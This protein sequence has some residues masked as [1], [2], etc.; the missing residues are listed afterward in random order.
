MENAHP[1]A[2]F[3]FGDSYV[4]TG[5]LKKSN[6]VAWK[7]P[8]GISFPGKPSGRHSDGKVFTD[9]IG[10][11]SNFYA[12]NYS[13]RVW[14]LI[15]DFNV[16]ASAF[17]IPIPVLHSQRDINSNML[18]FGMNFATGGTGVFSTWPRLPST[19]TQINQL[20]ELIGNGVYSTKNLP[21][22]LVLFYVPSNTYNAFI[23]QQRGTV[24]VIP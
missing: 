2:M 19:N 7:P 18:R 16:A 20:Q 13:F 15:C 14:V 21:S 3:V 8:Y 5:N 11:I 22:S 17:H 1:S 23:I 9:F 4:D 24:E 6:V 10:I 12:V